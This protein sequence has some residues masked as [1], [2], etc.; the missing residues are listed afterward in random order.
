MNSNEKSSFII[1]LDAM[2]LY[3]KSMSQRLPTK[4]S[5]GYRMKRYFLVIF[6]RIPE[7]P[8]GDDFVLVI[9]VH[10]PEQFHH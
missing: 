6:K 4:S 2:K 3:G 5:E 8:S 1:Y 9:D 7:S 10:Y